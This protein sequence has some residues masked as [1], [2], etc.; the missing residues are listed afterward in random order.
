M[1]LLLFKMTYPSPISAI[2]CEKCTHVLET[3]SQF[4]NQ[5]NNSYGPN[6]IFK[7]QITKILIKETQGRQY[8][9][10]NT[11]LDYYTD[12]G[13]Q[14]H[15]QYND[16]GEYCGLGTAFEVILIFTLMILISM[17]LKNTIVK[18]LTSREYCYM[19]TPIQQ[20]FML[21]TSGG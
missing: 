14:G 6:T 7:N 3:K 11:P 18:E 17:H 5:F 16:Q 20:Y 13:P 9:G 12:K 8:E 10:H 15:F 1:H 2:R 21:V 19:N 4:G